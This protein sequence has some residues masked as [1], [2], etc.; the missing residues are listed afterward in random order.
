MKIEAAPTEPA[1]LEEPRPIFALLATIKGANGYSAVIRTGE[2]E[3]RVVEVGDTLQDGFKVKSL[4]ESRAVLS[5]GR[6]T[7]VANRPRS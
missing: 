5:D 1:K 3:V 2:T 6:D 7:I 4:E